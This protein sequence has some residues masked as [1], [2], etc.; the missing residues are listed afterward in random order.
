MKPTVSLTRAVVSLTLFVTLAMLTE[1]MVQWEQSP[2][3]SAVFWMNI[4]KTGL[5]TTIAYISK[6]WSSK[7]TPQVPVPDTPVAVTIPQAA[8]DGAATGFRSP[9]EGA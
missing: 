9:P 4:A 7:D 5:I 6:T 3:L 2:H 8:A 1:A